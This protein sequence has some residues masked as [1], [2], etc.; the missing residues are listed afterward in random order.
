M[1]CDR[2][3]IVDHGRV[4]RE[5]SLGEVVGGAPEVRL[6]V[7]RADAALLSTLGGHGEVLNVEPTDGGQVAVVLGISDL[8][9]V[10]AVAR[11]VV[12]QGVA[13]Y[14]LVPSRRSLEEV[15]VSLV[16]GTEG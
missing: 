9:Q 6:T 13:L 3:A 2:V 14:G 10:P 12:S 15:F 11:T 16:E 1:V 7:D 8:E 4:V 5:G